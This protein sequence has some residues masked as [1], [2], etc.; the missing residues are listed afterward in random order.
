MVPGKLSN[1]PSCTAVLVPGPAQN[2]GSVIYLHRTISQRVLPYVPPP[3]TYIPYLM[4][5]LIKP[6]IHSPSLFLSKLNTHVFLLTVA[7]SP[8][9]VK[10]LR[11]ATLTCG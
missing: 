5:Y 10:Y 7:L 3:G 9:I 8:K 11:R 6:A 2:H 4:Y 1:M